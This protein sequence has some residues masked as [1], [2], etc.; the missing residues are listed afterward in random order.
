MII[1]KSGDVFFLETGTANSR[2]SCRRNQQTS[3]ITYRLYD[4]DRV[5]VA[6]NERELHVDLASDAITLNRHSNL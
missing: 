5:D 4:F 1:V 2:I 6:G 3:D